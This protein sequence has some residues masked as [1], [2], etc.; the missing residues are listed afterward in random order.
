MATLGKKFEV[1][2]PRI[3]S[4]TYGYGILTAIMAFSFIFTFVNS[5]GGLAAL[6]FLFGLI[7]A[8]VTV[9][10]FTQNQCGIS[11]HDH[12]LVIKQ[13]KPLFPLGDGFWFKEIVVPIQQLEDFRWDAD[14]LEQIESGRIERWQEITFLVSWTASDGSFQ[15]IQYQDS[16]EQGTIRRLQRATPRLEEM[17][18]ES[19]S[20][21]NYWDE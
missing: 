5:S 13:L 17:A 10:K 8:F 19:E 12:G 9:R 21:D 20:D 11:F 3:P 14:E 16:F 2:R 18:Q 1:F 6:F 15:E 7:S 4:E